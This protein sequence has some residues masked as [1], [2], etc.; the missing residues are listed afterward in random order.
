MIPVYPATLFPVAQ[1]LFTPEGNIVDN[2]YQ[3]RISD[4]ALKML[5]FAKIFKDK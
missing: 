3:K 1:E 5:D 4:M 2:S